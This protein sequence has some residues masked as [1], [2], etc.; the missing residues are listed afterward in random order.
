M[1]R[2]L[3]GGAADGAH[4]PDDEALIDAKLFAAD[5]TEFG[6]N[7]F[8]TLD[9]ISDAE[10]TLAG[11]WQR[12]HKP[13]DGE[14]AVILRQSGYAWRHVWK[15]FIHGVALVMICSTI[16]NLIVSHPK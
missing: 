12:G 1:A 3:A 4:R 7:G 14:T 11:V 5:P 16:M 15:T 6:S 2:R 13:W 10:V 8:V 9:L